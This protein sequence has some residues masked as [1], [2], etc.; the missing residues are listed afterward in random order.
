MI[1]FTEEVTMPAHT[2]QLEPTPGMEISNLGLG[3]KY[4]W[5]IHFYRYNLFLSIL[6]DG[7]VESGWV[8]DILKVGN[9]I[10]HQK[11]TGKGPHSLS[12]V[13]GSRSIFFTL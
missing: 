3:L 13:A 4:C 11:M 7:C 5:H 8:A 12:S 2:G 9:C 10:K 6:K 1:A